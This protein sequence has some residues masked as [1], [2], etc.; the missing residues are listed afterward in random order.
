MIE[1]LSSG[2]LVQPKLLKVDAIITAA[3]IR[4]KRVTYE[5]SYFNNGELK[6]I[7]L[8]ELEFTIK[9]SVFTTNKVG[10]K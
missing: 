10:F 8:S 4:D 1:L 3:C 6:N 2:T 9:E 5:L 7:W